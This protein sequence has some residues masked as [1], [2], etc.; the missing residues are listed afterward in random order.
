MFHKVN[1]CTLRLFGERLTGLSEVADAGV[2][3]L[4]GFVR[5]YCLYI[6]IYISF[7]NYFDTIAV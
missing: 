1:L 2:D 4:Y 3:W 7:Y 5:Y 6:Y